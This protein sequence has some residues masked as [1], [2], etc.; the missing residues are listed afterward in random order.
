M[1]WK[2]SIHMQESGRDW[3]GFYGRNGL[4]QEPGG[5]RLTVVVVV[6]E[7]S[8]KEE[9][10]EQVCLSENVGERRPAQDMKYQGQF[11]RQPCVRE[12]EVRKIRNDIKQA[13]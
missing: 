3:E 10:E 9:L 7:N 12:T 6:V 11:T 4:E 1:V 13:K 2:A 8:G 5:I